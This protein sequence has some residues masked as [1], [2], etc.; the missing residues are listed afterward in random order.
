MFLNSIVNNNVKWKLPKEPHFASSHV[1]AWTSLPQAQHEYP[2]SRTDRFCSPYKSSVTAT[3]TL[4]FRPSEKMS[5][6]FF[7]CVIP[8]L[9]TKN[10]RSEEAAS[11]AVGTPGSNPTARRGVAK[12]FASSTPASLSSLLCWKSLR[13]GLIQI[14]YLPKAEFSYLCQ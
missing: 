11:D 12:S 1:P 4:F 14:Q 9:A 10:T 8:T 5:A 13:S 3:A 6:L 7:S 2:L